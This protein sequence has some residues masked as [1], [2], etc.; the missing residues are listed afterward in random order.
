MVARLE[1]MES[2]DS[3]VAVKNCRTLTECLRRNFSVCH[4][5]PYS[6]GEELM[7]QVSKERLY[8]AVFPIIRGHLMCLKCHFELH[9]RHMRQRKAKLDF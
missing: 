6:E 8:V 9:V 7:A 3:S 1:C 5:Q 2:M 4:G